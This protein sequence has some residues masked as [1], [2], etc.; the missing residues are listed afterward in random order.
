[1]VHDL[2]GLLFLWYT[3][4]VSVSD[5]I[6]IVLAT[7]TFVGV[8]VALALGIV[9]IRETRNLQRIGY[10]NKLLD[11]ILEWAL[12]ILAVAHHGATT[13]VSTFEE[14][15][16]NVRSMKIYESMQEGNWELGYRKAV[17]RGEYMINMSSI[18]GSALQDSIK[19]LV[20][21]LNAQAEVCRK[22]RL[23][24]SDI[25]DDIHE[26]SKSLRQSVAE[27]EEQ[28]PKMYEAVAKVVREATRLIT[29]SLKIQ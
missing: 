5:T 17:Y 11:A 15:T 18:F 20:T 24:F 19:A 25:P 16:K 10:R 4:S 12:S 7:L 28:N 9:S 14:G 2:S 23:A 26:F 8:L 1:M 22:W 29:M 3:T 6:G 21:E 13:D 27:S